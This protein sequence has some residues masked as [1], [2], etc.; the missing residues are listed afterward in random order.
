MAVNR[1]KDIVEGIVGATLIAFH[2][3]LN[4]LFRSWRVTWGANEEELKKTFPGDEL[5]PHPKWEYTHAVTI[6][7]PA[8]EVWPWVVQIGQ[9]R[10]GFYSYE[11][12]ENLVGCNIHNTDRIIPEFQ[13]LKAG[14][15]IRLHPKAPPTPVIGV[16]L[17][18]WLLLGIAPDY[19]EPKGNYVGAT[20]LFF[21][22]E[23]NKNTTRLISHGRNDY[24][25][26]GL[27]NRLWFGPTLMEPI[28]FVMG[29][30][31]LLGIKERAEA[32]TKRSA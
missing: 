9:G 17:G 24:N 10:G 4:P 18:G 3:L 19:S 28:N 22:D 23:K 27:A 13:K 26:P 21:L 25:N 12:L 6:D 16:E 5:I 32:A 20:W 1:L 30:K 31:M 8:A 7:V 2:L 15:S 11:L 29:R 14:D